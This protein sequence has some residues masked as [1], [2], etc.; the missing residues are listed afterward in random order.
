MFLYGPLVCMLL[1]CMSVF[2]VGVSN[3]LLAW[4]VPVALVARALWCVTWRGS[5]RTTSGD[6][7]RTRVCFDEPV[8][9]VTVE[10]VSRT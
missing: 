5:V 1:H 7:V 9:K 2:N 4:L 10:T 8:P 3:P 6:Q